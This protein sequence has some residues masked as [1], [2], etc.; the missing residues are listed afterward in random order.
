M[1]F[2]VSFRFVLSFFFFSSHLKDKCVP[3][4]FFAFAYFASFC[5]AFTYLKAE[6]RLACYRLLY[7]KQRLCPKLDWNFS[8][9]CKIKQRL[10]RLYCI[11]FCFI[12]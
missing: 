6:V 3:F 9:V 2:F 1:N 11:K 12:E 4:A 7:I 5:F 8:N 10:N